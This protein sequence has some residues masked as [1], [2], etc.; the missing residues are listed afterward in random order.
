MY[1]YNII[2]LIRM[3]RTANKNRSINSKSDYSNNRSVH[4]KNGDKFEKFVLQIPEIRLRFYGS[5]FI[6]VGNVFLSIKTIPLHIRHWLDSDTQTFM[7]ANR[8]N[9]YYYI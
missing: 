1:T 9:K 8:P 6:R 2:R 7:T 5:L 4:N 3:F